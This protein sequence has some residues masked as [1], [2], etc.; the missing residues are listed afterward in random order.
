[1]ASTKVSLNSKEYAIV[2]FENGNAVQRNSIDAF[3]PVQRTSAES[4][5]SQ[6]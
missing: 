1:M 3:S 5:A 2:P 6:I 4:E